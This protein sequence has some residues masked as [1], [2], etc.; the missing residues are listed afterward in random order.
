MSDRLD[1][2][3]TFD[4]EKLWQVVIAIFLAWFIG[5]LCSLFLDE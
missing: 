4:V 3:L 5:K 1:K 2:L